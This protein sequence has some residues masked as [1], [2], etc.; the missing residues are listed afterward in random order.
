MEPP[1]PIRSRLVLAMSPWYSSGF[2]FFR[3]PFFLRLSD[4]DGF[5]HKVLHPSAFVCKA[6]SNVCTMRNFAPCVS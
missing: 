1:L 3:W 4:L 6:A 2:A 5:A